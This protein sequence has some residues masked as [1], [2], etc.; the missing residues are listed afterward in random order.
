[1]K[2]LVKIFLLFIIFLWFF[3]NI[4]FS[5]A[6]Q[7]SQINN[8]SWIQVDKGTDRNNRL[9]NFW[10]W[11][12]WFAQ[13]WVNWA[14][15]FYYTLIEIAHSL[16]N[17]M[18]IIATIFYIII[19]IKLI[20]VENT[21]EQVWKF[22]KW[23]IWITAWLVVM[24]MAYVYSITLFSQQIWEALA[25][26]LINNIINP[27]IWLLEVLASIFFIAIAIFAYYRM[28]TAHWNEEE[29]KR[30]KM[31]IVYAIMWFI[32]MK[33]AKVIVEWVYWKLE[34]RS[35]TVAGYDIVTTNCIWETQTTQLTS[36]F[37][38]IINW[39]NWFIWIITI[40]LIIY[41]G[42]MVLISW[43][44][45]EKLKKAKNILIYIIIGIFILSI[46]Y[47]ILTFFILPE[48]TI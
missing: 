31:S 13:V 47:L 24:Q 15:W 26:D 32:L 1:M 43:W 39:M 14:R 19:A 42:F 6:S 9:T 12:S 11:K 18:Y 23:I 20:V 29:V 46:N 7:V 2:V 35:E 10:K 28:V 3:W 40:I 16:K 45:E 48:V 21:E 41:A 36:T 44:D 38:Q 37:M 17:L 27:L 4:N 8:E 34:C 30:A 25:V 22:K 5:Q 33:L